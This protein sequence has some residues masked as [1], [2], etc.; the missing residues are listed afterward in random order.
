[1]PALPCAVFNNRPKRAKSPRLKRRGKAIRAP[2]RG[3]GK[4]E[5]YMNK[6]Y[7][8]TIEKPLL[9][10]YYDENMESP[11]E[12]SN[13]G[14]FITVDHKHNSPDKNEVIED[15]VKNTQ[16]EANN[17]VEHMKLITK[18]I[19]ANTGEYEKMFSL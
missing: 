5:K 10:I 17:L 16:Y 12:W 14:Y 15:I 2:I 7:K 8:T 13:L 9:K 3:E 1:L 6:T 19:K 4:K 11:R 18:E